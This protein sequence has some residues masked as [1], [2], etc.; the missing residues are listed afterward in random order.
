MRIGNKT[1][2]GVLAENHPVW[3]GGIFVRDEYVSIYCPDHPF[4]N[5]KYVLLHRLIMEHY[6]GRYLNPEEQVH[7]INGIKNDNRIENLRLCA[8]ASEH[9]GKFHRFMNPNN[10]ETQRQCGYCKL[11]LELNDKNFYRS[12][13]EPL[14]FRGLCKKC[15]LDR[16][17]ASINKRYVQ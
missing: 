3:K 2:L 10:S 4:N 12:K 15:T 8:S 1:M 11:I 6:L 16:N 14:G 9:H 13:K 5:K 17:K 7:H